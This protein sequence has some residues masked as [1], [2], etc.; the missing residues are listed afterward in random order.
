MGR[1]VYKTGSRWALWRWTDVDFQGE[2]YLLRLHILKT[3]WFGFMLNW[4]KS[5]DPH[6]DPHDHP[7]NFL[8]IVLRGGYVE[9]RPQGLRDRKV[10]LYR[11]KDIHRI[12]HAEPGTLTLCIAG[13]KVRDWGFHTSEGFVPWREYRT[14]FKE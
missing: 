5:A 3:P 14:A 7:V 11:A 9:W 4:I 2:T 12:V 1:R 13:E 8:S 6:P 10:R